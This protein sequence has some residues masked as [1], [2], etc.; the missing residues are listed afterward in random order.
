MSIP[1]PAVAPAA[2]S[3]RIAEAA[4]E[5]TVFATNSSTLLPSAI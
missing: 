2:P 3:F 5:R 4:P 1:D